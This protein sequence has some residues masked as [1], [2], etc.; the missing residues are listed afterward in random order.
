MKQNTFDA[1]II[2]GSYAGLSGAM[3][4]GR[5]IRKVLI[6]DSDN[7]CN[8]Q[9]PY[10]HNFLTQDGSTPAE[11]RAKAI[12]Q[13][14]AY[15]TITFVKDKA[16]SV[17]KDGDLFEILTGKGDKYTATKLL[18]A[19][20]VNDQIP[21]I[22][23]FAACWG[24]SIIHCPYCHGY[25]VKGQKTA[26]MANGDIAFHMTAL[27]SNWTKEI[28]LLTNGKSTLSA[29]QNALLNKRGIQVIETKIT[30][31]KQDKGHLEKV[32]FADGNSLVIS[33]MYAKIPFSQHSDIP[34]QLGCE[35]TEEGYI[36]VDEL[37]KTTVP[38]IYAAGDNTT[39]ARAVAQ[40]VWA[41]ARAGISINNELIFELTDHE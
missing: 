5:A 21:D 36:K 28:I 27:I 9:T 2:G 17:Q 7:P 15:P 29:E 13:V 33:V 14:L 24:I 8:K 23:G 30:A 12:E 31:V 3:A 4:L 18:F 6:I 32:V 19:T 16:L 25:E 34:Q 1:I 11:I 38:G 35:L 10:S 37:Q 39:M 40:A 20:G 41:G 22:D 26:I